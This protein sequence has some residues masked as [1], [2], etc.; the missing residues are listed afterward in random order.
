MKLPIL[1]LLAT[2][3]S[4]SPT[5]LE[6]LPTAQISAP[7]LPVSSWEIAHYDPSTM[8]SLDRAILADPNNA[9]A[10]HHRGLLWI[11]VEDYPKAI[12]DFSEVI[13]IEPNNS[14]AYNYRGTALFWSRQYDE[15]LDDYNRAIE[16]DEN[17]AT[18]YFNR[19]YLH[20]QFG[21]IQEAIADFRRGAELSRQQK[22][23]D[24]YQQALEIL[25][26]LEKTPQ[27]SLSALFDR[28]REKLQRGDFLGAV[29]DFNQIL[30]QTNSKSQVYYSLGLA[31]MGLEDYRGAIAYFDAAIRDNSRF[32]EAYNQRGEALI[33]LEDWQTA[34]M[35]FNLA[36]EL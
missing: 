22:D 21:R 3:L 7:N 25:S 17:L 29:S 11:H 18:A 33:R 36:L 5:F 19:G 28:G 35:D 9:E 15:A 4:G 2:S 10:Y 12:A 27:L 20:R 16:L 34:L 23:N 14:Q 31:Q 6:S 1:A 24:A 32:V 26:D 13:R 30:P 8:E